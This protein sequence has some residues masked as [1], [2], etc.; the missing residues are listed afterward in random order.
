MVKAMDDTFGKDR[1]YDIISLDYFFSPA[2]WVN[3]RWSEKL[4][5][6]TI[7]VLASKKLKQNGSI[8]IPNNNHVEAMLEKH[9]E[10]ISKTCSWIVVEDPN[11]NPLYLATDQVTDELSACPDNLTNAT[12][13][14]YL[15]NSSGPFLCFKPLEEIEEI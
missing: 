8:W 6:E 4:F 14:E 13:I 7:P 15:K 12:Q 2:G 9:Q 10:I 1:Q 3:D 5:S 11:Q